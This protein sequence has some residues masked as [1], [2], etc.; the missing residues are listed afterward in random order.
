MRSAWETGVL[1]L[2]LVGWLGALTLQ[3]ALAARHPD[4]SRGASVDETSAVALETSSPREL[5]RLPGI[6]EARALEIA[7]ERWRL[8]GSGQAL[9]LESLPGVGPTTSERVARALEPRTTPSGP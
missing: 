3:R 5:R 8:R 1:G 9:R 7:R 4:A 2:A 6:G